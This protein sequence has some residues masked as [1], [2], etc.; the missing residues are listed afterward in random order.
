M[1]LDETILAAIRAI[2]NLPEFSDGH[3]TKAYQLDC[4]VR[5]NAIIRVTSQE[6]DDPD[7]S[8]NELAASAFRGLYEDYSDSE[9][10]YPD[11]FEDW[12]TDEVE[13]V[14]LQYIVM[15]SF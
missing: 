4:L 11:F 14:C 12:S 13:E 5:Y 2:N 3:D 7:I 1:T 6:D 9:E 15:L 10:D 8:V